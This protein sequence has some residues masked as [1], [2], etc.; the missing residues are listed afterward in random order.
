MIYCLAS[1]ASV[2]SMVDI[3]YLEENPLNY[4]FRLTPL[5][6]GICLLYTVYCIAPLNMVSSSNPRFALNPARALDLPRIPP[7]P[8]IGLEL[9]QG[10]GVIM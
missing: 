9:S 4:L 8:W 10:P 7:G 6:V 3:A 1:V 2:E 5:A